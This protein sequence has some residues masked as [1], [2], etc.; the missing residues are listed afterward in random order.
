LKAIL[1]LDQ[2]LFWFGDYW[3]LSNAEGQLPSNP[4]HLGNTSFDSYFTDSD[5]NDFY[6]YGFRFI[7]KLFNKRNI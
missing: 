7:E 1:N 3:N 2:D 4:K 6:D 5:C